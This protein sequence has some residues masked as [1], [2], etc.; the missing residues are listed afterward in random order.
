MAMDTF[1]VIIS[2]RLEG[3]SREQIEAALVDGA[4]RLAMFRYI[5]L[6]QIA[7]VSLTLIL[8]R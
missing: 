2:C 4:N 7:P 1:H 3:V 8:I 6:P 5:I